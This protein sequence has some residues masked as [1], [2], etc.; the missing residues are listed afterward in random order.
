MIGDKDKPFIF[1]S[2][3]FLVK[4]VKI[5]A[6]RLIQIFGKNIQTGLKF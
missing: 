1:S 4:S 5:Q 6:N 2:T 3:V